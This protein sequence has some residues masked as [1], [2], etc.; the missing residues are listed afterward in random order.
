MSWLAALAQLLARSALI[1]F[2]KYALQLLALQLLHTHTT[3]GRGE[4]GRLW[5]RSRG[6]AKGRANLFH[7]S[8]RALSREATAN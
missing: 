1:D 3:S 8:R 6:A 4:L 2:K 5:L 7:S